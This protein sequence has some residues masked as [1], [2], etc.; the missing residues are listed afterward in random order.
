MGDRHDTD[1]SYHAA[2]STGAE[3]SPEV[4]AAR[5]RAP[6]GYNNRGLP[7]RFPRRTG[8]YEALGRD[9]AR[10][11]DVETF[12]RLAFTGQQPAVEVATAPTEAGWKAR[13]H[14]VCK[15]GGTGFRK[16]AYAPTAA[17]AVGLLLASLETAAL[18]KRNAIDEAFAAKAK[19]GV[20]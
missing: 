18:D 7:N 20:R 15:D 17:A 5:P 3:D 12:F 8:E 13:V 10:R 19:R 14:I 4:S 1:F 9:D 2:L 16:T 11:A 6:Y